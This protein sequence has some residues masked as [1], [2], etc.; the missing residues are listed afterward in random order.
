MGQIFHPW[1]PPTQGCQVRVQ[2]SLRL[3]GG[4]PLLI[5]S[6][7]EVGNQLAAAA[8]AKSPAA[9]PVVAP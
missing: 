7:G 4:L 1:S 8:Q 3:Q 6:R 2:H 5:E 9:E